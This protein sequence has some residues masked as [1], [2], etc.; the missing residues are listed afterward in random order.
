MNDLS[1][2]NASAPIQV[3]N[4]DGTPAAHIPVRFDQV[5]HDFS[6]LEPCDTSKLGAV[7]YES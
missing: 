4:P 6:T 5:K 3:L 2:R 7:I 1:H